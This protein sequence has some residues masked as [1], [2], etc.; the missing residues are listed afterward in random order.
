M[1]PHPIQRLFVYF[2]VRRTQ[3]SPQVVR[4]K[5]PRYSGYFVFTSPS[6]T[7]VSPSRTL[8]RYNSIFAAEEVLNGRLIKATISIML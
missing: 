7:R 3:M 5:S 6:R 2:I 4:E 1:S 8:T